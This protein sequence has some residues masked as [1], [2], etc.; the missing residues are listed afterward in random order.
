M[1]RRVKERLVGASILVVLIVLIV[2]ELLSG[3]A[4]A[5]VGPK[6]PVS[7]PE[8]VRNVTVD[9]A[10]A[11]APALEP[12]MDPAAPGAAASAATASG[13]PAAGPPPMT[14]A[15]PAAGA[16][17]ATSGPSAA[18]A[19]RAVPAEP[20]E[21]APPAPTTAAA[22]GAKPAA[23]MHGWAVQLGSFASRANADKLARQVKGQGFS[24][25]VSPGGSGAAQRY[26]VRI[27]PLA[28]RTAATQTET[29]LRALGHVGTVV[30]PAT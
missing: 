20:L 30:P 29:K 7:A 11:K 16:P 9:L 8:P 14:A 25:F 17:P 28:D 21:S 10:T 19:Q 23:A 22:A 1:D 24:V 12:A 15:V 6:L 13:V 26:R 3:P 2:P 27:G 5:P 18:T 4:P